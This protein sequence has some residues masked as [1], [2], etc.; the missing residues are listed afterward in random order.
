VPR[1]LRL[2]QNTP[3]PFN[4]RTSIEFDVPERCRVRLQVFGVDG[5]EV[6]TLVDEVLGAGVYDVPWNGIDDRGVAVASGVYFYVLDAGGLR[7]T[8]KMV[9]M[10]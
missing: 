2:R 3:N 5:R 6:A 7:L 10:R 1:A 9:L 4:P 8:Q